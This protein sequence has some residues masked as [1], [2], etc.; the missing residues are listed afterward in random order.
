MISGQRKL[1]VSLHDITPFH[2]ERIGRAE[3]VYREL[4]LSKLTYLFV[5]EYH[6]GYPAAQDMAF[7][8]WC[9]EERPFRIDWHLH[10]YCHL[11]PPPQPGSWGAGDF[12]KR[13][14]LTAGEGEFLALD[15]EAQ[16]RKLEAGREAFRTCLGKDPVGFVAPAWLFNAHLPGALKDQGFRFTEDQRR[17]YRVDT[18]ASLKSPVI[19]WATRTWLRKYG[20]LVVCPLL[21]R[22]WSQAPVLRVAMHPFDFD[23]PATVGNIRSVLAAAMRDREQAFAE[24]L[25]FASAGAA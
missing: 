16:R 23:H 12:L 6:G 8:A 25:D 15:A 22:L 24:D 7:R 21:L 5:P 3:A 18:G 13:K 2:R 19:T 9:R 11:E 14:L 20:S 1:V 4:G 17:M 10:G